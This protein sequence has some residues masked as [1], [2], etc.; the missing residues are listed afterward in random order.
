MVKNSKQQNF[1]KV[2]QFCRENPKKSFTNYEIQQ[3]FGLNYSQAKK[4]LSSLIEFKELK[5]SDSLK[6]YV[7]VKNDNNNS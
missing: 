6:L 4:I 5:Y 7:G 1:E 3:K 2:R